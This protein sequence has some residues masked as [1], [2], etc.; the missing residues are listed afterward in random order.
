[1]RQFIYYFVKSVSIYMTEGQYVHRYFEDKNVVLV[2]G[3][4]AADTTAGVNA[5]NSGSLNFN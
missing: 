1:M 4:S 2:Y 3:Y 5:L